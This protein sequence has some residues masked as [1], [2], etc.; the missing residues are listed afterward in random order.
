MIS[1]T[2]HL[3][4]NLV[5]GRGKAE[6]IGKMTAAYGRHA[7][8]VTGRSSAKRTGL[9]AAVLAQ[10][11]AEGVACTVFDRV[12]PNPLTTTAH[13][14]AA[15]AVAGGCDVVLAL[16]GGSSIDAAKGVA[17]MAV[18]G[19][20]V[21]DYIFGRAVGSQALPIIAVPTTCGTGSEGNGFAV[22]TDPET[23]DKKSLRTNAVVPACS[24]VDPL[25]MTT[26][27]KRLLAAVGFDALC[28][29]IEAYLSNAAQPMTDLLAAEGVRLAARSLPRVYADA[30]DLDA[31]D[32]LCLASTFGGM[33]INTAG[34]TALHGMEHPVSGLKDAEH[35]SGLAALA[36]AVYD[37]SVSAAPRKFAALS[38][39][40]GGADERDFT[41]RLCALLADIRLETTLGDLGVTPADT[42]WLADNCMKVSAG[43]IANHPAAF[44][45]DEIKS[46]YTQ[47]IQ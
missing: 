45:R 10:L 16:G 35:G 23:M 4:V 37:R 38:R 32:E 34:V 28:H 29:N 2:Y 9:L 41:A 1:F 24:I 13:E 22:L 6:S 44:T 27:P 33:A 40:M 3:P 39:L 5:F 21:S 11:S 17:F 42:D 43:G 20:N 12:A 14:G 19:G 46:I 18:N 47:A 25:L 8:L 31:W 7:L 26:M 36:C 15:L 30:A